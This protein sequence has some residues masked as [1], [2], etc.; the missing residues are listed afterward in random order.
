[1][2]NSNGPELRGT[3]LRPH[4]YRLFHGIAML[5]AASL[6]VSNTVAV[7]VIEVWGFVLPAGII[8]FP[9]AYIIN[10]CLT[11]VYGY[12][13]TR[14]AIWFGFGCLGFM[15]IVYYLAMLLPPAAFWQD[16]EAFSKLFGLTPR[17]AAASF[18]A[19]LV[20]SFL[21][22][23]VM[24]RMK[25]ATKGR[26][27]WTRTIGSTIVGEGADSFVFNIVAFSGVF[28]FD[29]VLFIALSGFVLKTAYEVLATPL[30]YAAVR[31]LKRVE[32][33]DKYDHDIRYTPFGI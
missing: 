3:T 30:T 7:K 29:R 15:S 17:I 23:V 20:G 2:R 27:L 24:S 33:E 12:E 25:V 32:S 11:E 28:P 16:Q 6:L 4:G 18:I 22:S 26:F 31:W 21:N 5:F 8:C 1:M 9:V 10:D 13:K 14:S 19:Y